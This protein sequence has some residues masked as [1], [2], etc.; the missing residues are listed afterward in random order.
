MR[1]I[2][3]VLRLHFEAGLGHRKIAKVLG[4]SKGAVGN[5]LSLAK[6]KGIG[7]PL[8]ENLDEQ[9]LEQ[10]I[11]PPAQGKSAHLVEPDY[12]VIHQ[13]LKRKGVTLQLLWSEYVGV[14]EEHAHQYSRYCELYRSWAGKQKR[15]MR[16][17]HRAGEKLFIDYCG[18]TVDIIDGTTGEVRKA[19]VFV[20]VLGCFQLYLRGSHLDPGTFRLDRLAS[21]G[22]SLLWW[23]A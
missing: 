12:P 18:P 8:P 16:Q 5:Y 2:K 3:E 23:G 10:C 1:K 20:A 19:Q 15:S 14:H 7:W 6:A 4:I 22:L 17:H 11:S 13:E 21:A 9:N